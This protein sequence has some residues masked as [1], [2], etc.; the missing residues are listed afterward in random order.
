[1]NDQLKVTIIQSN[2]F[3]ED[4]LANLKGFE[5]KINKIS[6]TDLIVLPEMFTT[7]FTMNPKSMAETM[8]GKTVNWML[9]IASEHKCLLRQ[10][11]RNANI[12]GKPLYAHSLEQTTMR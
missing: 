3:W 5:K 6:H 4:K 7:G 9:N 10:S 11:Q 12:L 2:L 8:D 1:M